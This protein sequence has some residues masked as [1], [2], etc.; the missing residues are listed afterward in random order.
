M[1][2]KEDAKIRASLEK[3]LGKKGNKWG[4]EDEKVWKYIRNPRR[5]RV[6]PSW[7]GNQWGGDQEKVW[8]YIR[9]LTRMRV[10]PSGSGNVGRH[11]HSNEARYRL[12]VNTNVLPESGIPIGRNVE[13]RPP[14]LYTRIQGWNRKNIFNL[15]Q[16]LVNAELSGLVLAL[17]VKERY[18]RLW[19]A[20]LEALGSMFQHLLISWHQCSSIFLM[21]GGHATS[22]KCS[23]LGPKFFGPWLRVLV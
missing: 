8:K 5:M 3:K 11:G 13:I 14:G 15:S 23:K 12:E 4:G 19:E 2:E 18:H 6:Q 9:N 17:R 10:Q 20:N 21:I 1:V 22:Q 7:S 16:L